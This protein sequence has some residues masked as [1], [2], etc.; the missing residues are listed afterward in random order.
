MRFVVAIAE[1]LIFGMPTPAKRDDRSAGEA[2]FFSFRVVNC[3]VSFDTDRSVVVYRDFSGCHHSDGIKVG[4]NG[5]PG[6]L[7]KITSGTTQNAVA[8]TVA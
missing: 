2:V 5:R 6:S 4:N 8:S 7:L 3:E 1:R